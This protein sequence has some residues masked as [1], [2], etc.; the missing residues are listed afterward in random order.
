MV[1][2]LIGSSVEIGLV[3]HPAGSPRRP[4][5][6]RFAR[7]PCSGGTA[8]PDRPAAPLSRGAVLPVI[9]AEKNY[10]RIELCAVMGPF[11]VSLH[12]KTSGTADAERRYALEAAIGR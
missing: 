1:V 9:R 12:P 7:S 4:P 11:S 3:D 6:H 2:R 8:E 5:Y 10:F